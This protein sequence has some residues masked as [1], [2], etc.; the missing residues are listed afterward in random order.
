MDSEWIICIRFS[1]IKN[2]VGT[3]PPMRKKNLSRITYI[4]NRGGPLPPPHAKGKTYPV[5][6]ISE[7]GSLKAKI[8][9]NFGRIING[10]SAKMGLKCTICIRFSKN[11]SGRPRPTPCCKRIKNSP[12]GFIWSSGGGFSRGGTGA[13]APPPPRQWLQAW[14]Y[15]YYF[16]TCQSPFSRNFMI[17]DHEGAH[18]GTNAWES[19]K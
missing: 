2:R 3:P 17:T 5:S 12:L 8:T 15:T 9:H 10:Q 1:K 14:V 16:L 6:R 13:R 19:T 4:K 11:F 7:I 18:L